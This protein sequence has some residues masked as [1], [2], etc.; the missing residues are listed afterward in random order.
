MKALVMSDL[1]IEFES[2]RGPSRPTS[3]WCALN[4]L[5]KVTLGHP[6]VGPDLRAAKAEGVQ[7]ALVAGDTAVGARATVTYARQVSEYLSCPVVLVCG[8]HEAYGHDLEQLITEMRATAGLMPGSEVYFLENERLD[9]DVAGQKLIIL[10]CTL[11][12]DYALTGAAKVEGAIIEAVGSLNDHVCI[13]FRGNRL[14]PYH[15]RQM[16]DVSRKWLARELAKA[17]SETPDVIVMT[18]HAPVP[19]AIPPKYR[20]GRLSAA[21]ASDLEA[22]IAVGE[23][24]GA[25]LWACGH[26][27]HSFSQQVGGTLVMA[28]QRGYVGSEAGADCY[29]PAII[30]LEELAR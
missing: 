12:T 25:A 11:W 19:E 20:G 7:V 28:S 30:D 9:L 13:Q 8:N 17:R 22:E 23:L 27:H 15:C 1:H 5:R 26:T 29:V 14:H 6:P 16:H 24:Q 21:F 2:G 18:H 10:G 3:A 4:A